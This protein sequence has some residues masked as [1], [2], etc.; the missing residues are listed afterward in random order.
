MGGSGAQV[1]AN[2]KKNFRQVCRGCRVVHRFHWFLWPS[3]V[4]FPYNTLSRLFSVFSYRVV[5]PFARS[6]HIC[7]QPALSPLTSSA[8]ASTSSSRPLKSPS[9]A[10]HSSHTAGVSKLMKSCYVPQT[11]CTYWLRNLCMKVGASLRSYVLPSP[12]GCNRPLLLACESGVPHVFTLNPQ[13]V[14]ICGM[15]SSTSPP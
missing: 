1:N 3:L 4:S 8:G 2:S 7:K 9:S 10:A 12:C 5:C 15:L 11:V 14:F 6:I 13:I